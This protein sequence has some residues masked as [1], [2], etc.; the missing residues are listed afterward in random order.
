MKIRLLTIV[1]VLTALI[2]TLNGP[3]AGATNRRPLAPNARAARAAG[4]QRPNVVRSAS[5][6]A[7]YRVYATQYKPNKRGS[8]E[9]AVPDKCV[10]FASLGW[11]SALQS[12]AC[13]AG[14]RLGLDYKVRIRT[15]SGAVLTARVKDVGPWN[16]DDNYWD[17][18]T[19]PRPRRRFGRLPRGTPEAQ[20]AFYNGVHT[21]PDC[22]TLSGAPSGHAGPADQ[23]G[24]CVLNPAG[25]DLSL[26]AARRLGFA[27]LQSG[28]VTV[29]FLWEPRR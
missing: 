15:A 3:A 25:I 6:F 12:A 7:T 29:S 20:A 16:E 17:A 2:A 8:V 21:V 22:T 19:G 10:K 18:T 27:S 23:F 13:P 26:A 14:Y 28:W 4:R 24:R 5:R 1:F 9:V 11:T